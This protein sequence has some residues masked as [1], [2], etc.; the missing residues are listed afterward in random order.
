MQD[1]NVNGHPVNKGQEAGSVGEIIDKKD[2][3][4]VRIFVMMISY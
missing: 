2:I 3:Y 1:V 4:T